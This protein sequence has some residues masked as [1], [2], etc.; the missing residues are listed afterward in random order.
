MP[1]LKTAWSSSFWHCDT[2]QCHQNQSEIELNDASGK[3]P[4][5]SSGPTFY[6]DPPFS[7]V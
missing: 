2:N 6:I 3:S 1:S 7:S 5:E 4:D